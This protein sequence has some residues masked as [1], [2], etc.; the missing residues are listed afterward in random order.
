ME[1]QEGCRR[2]TR[3][4]G[5]S[6]TISTESNDQGDFLHLEYT[7]QNECKGEENYGISYKIFCDSDHDSDPIFTL[8][9]AATTD[10]RPTFVTTHK[11][12]CKTGDLNGLWRF[13]EANSV[14][15]GIIFLVLGLYNLVLGRKL[16]RPTIGLIFCLATI[17]VILF[18]FYVLLLPN[19]VAQWVGWLLLVISI[20][21]GGIAGFF[22]SKL[23]RVG[24][25]L[26]GVGAGAC[27]G[28]LLNN[29]VFYRI[30]HVAVL[31]VLMSV[32]GLALGVLSFFW[33]NYIV[34]IC[35]SILGSYMFIRGISLF[36]GGFPNEFTVVKRIQ[37]G[38]IDGVP[39]TWWAYL[40]GL[41]V[42]LALG[43]FIQIKIK[44][45]EGD[46][47]ADDVYRRV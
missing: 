15:F 10:C 41:V 46:D 18:L 23:V 2:L 19:A 43:I 22:A 39:G 37:N 31:W 6:E 30:N 36:A 4:A 33:Y 38:D 34:I 1:F 25:F 24:V 17:V 21:L 3:N 7:T 5:Q 47:K 8:D 32:I 13:V 44:Q 29:L 16:I 42:V 26:I 27:I 40:A 45:R 35:T 9:E 20:I 11:A 28:L 12:G 14:I